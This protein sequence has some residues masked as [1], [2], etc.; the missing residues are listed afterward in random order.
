MILVFLASVLLPTP[1]PA[2][3]NSA[4]VATSELLI[5]GAQTDV[6]Y[7]NKNVSNCTRFASSIQKQ[8]VGPIGQDLAGF[9]T[10]LNRYSNVAPR[11]CT[12]R[13]DLDYVIGTIAQR[14]AAATTP[15]SQLMGMTGDEAMTKALSAGD[16]WP[17]CRADDPR[18][19]KST[20]ELKTYFA[21]KLKLVAL[22]AAAAS[23]KADTECVKRE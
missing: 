11:S 14:L 9:A 4:L 21:L 3:V 18:D 22:R 20:R 17:D 7:L 2:S 8:L 19:P 23:L 16:G 12:S 6:A 13:A 1:S 15:Q 5:E 10:R